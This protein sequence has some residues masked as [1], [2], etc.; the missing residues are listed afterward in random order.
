MKP[1]KCMRCDAETVINSG[2]SLEFYQCPVC[3]FAVRHLLHGG[4]EYYDSL[5]LKWIEV[6]EG[7]LLVTQR[8]M[9]EEVC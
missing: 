1:I 7:C 3:S 9:W 5:K 6:P 8:L 4:I 2:G